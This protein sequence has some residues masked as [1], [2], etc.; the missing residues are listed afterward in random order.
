MAISAKSKIL[1]SDINT[2]LSGKQDVLGYIPVKS[3]NG[4]AADAAGNVA[5]SV[6]ATP[7]AYVTTTYVSETQGY[8]KWSDGFIEQWGTTTSTANPL[9]VT[10][11]TAFTTTNYNVQFTSNNDKTTVSPRIY[12]KS[13]AEASFV[14]Q[15]GSWD[16][17][18]MWYACGF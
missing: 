4:V 11:P 6:P 13:K 18:G 14:V 1:A 15:Q 10:L 5:I 8:R 9:T 2:A 17:R 3:V 12:I 7:K 16:T